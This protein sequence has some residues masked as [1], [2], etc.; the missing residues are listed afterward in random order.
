LQLA[1]SSHTAPPP[2][3]VESEEPPQKE[4]IK[5]IVITVRIVNNLTKRSFIAF[6]SPE[7]YL[8]IL[9]SFPIFVNINL[10]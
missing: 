8:N 4:I 6:S 10:N 7:K 1:P 2:A 9:S 3:S 5:I